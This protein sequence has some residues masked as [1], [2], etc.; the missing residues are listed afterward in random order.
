ML[1]FE[2]R[3]GGNKCMQISGRLSNVAVETQKSTGKITK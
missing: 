2:Y 1:S 3:Q